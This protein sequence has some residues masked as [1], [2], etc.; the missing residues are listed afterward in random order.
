MSST[1][2]MTGHM[3]GA[4]GAVEIMATLLGMQEG[5]I[6]PTAGLE[7]KDPQ[8]DLDYVPLKMRPHKIATA[9][10]ISMGFGGQVATIALRKL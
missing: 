6:P 8:C 2:G 1:K 10:K 5:F 9:I 7:T 3:L 4:T